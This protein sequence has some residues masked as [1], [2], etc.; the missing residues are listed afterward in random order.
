M[1]LSLRA[2]RAALAED[3]GMTNR[4]A[5]RTGFNTLDNWSHKTPTHSKRKRTAEKRLKGHGPEHVYN[6]P[7]YN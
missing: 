4:R 6:T 5:Q 2:G 7:G 3:M 1:S